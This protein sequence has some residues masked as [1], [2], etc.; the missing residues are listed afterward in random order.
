VLAVEATRLR[1]PDWALLVQ[2]RDWPMD[3]MP[4]EK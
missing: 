4:K 3:T 2:L 1:D